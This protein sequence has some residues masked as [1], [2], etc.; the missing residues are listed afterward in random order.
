MLIEGCHHRMDSKLFS[1]LEPQVEMHLL[2]YTTAEGKL[3]EVQFYIAA[4]TRGGSPYVHSGK[5]INV[6]KVDNDSYIHV[7]PLTK[8]KRSSATSASGR[9]VSEVCARVW[10][11]LHQVVSDS[12]VS[13]FSR[14]P[15]HARVWSSLLGM[16]S[17]SVVS[18]FSRF[19]KHARICSCCYIR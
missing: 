7:Q 19:S 4:T 15:K 1:T 8:Y 5:C 2:D 6:N 16:A 14:L 10:F 11:S 17:D 3:V 9:H 18:T 13:T 12:V